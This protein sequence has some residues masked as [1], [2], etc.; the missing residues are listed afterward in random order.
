MRK[1]NGN[2]W[3]SPSL[4]APWR[5]TDEPQ[6]FPTHLQISILAHLSKVNTW[7]QCLKRRPK[8][9]RDYRINLSASPS[10]DLNYYLHVFLWRFWSALTL[11]V[12]PELDL[13]EAYACLLVTCL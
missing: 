11:A 2:L 12:L 4:V 3:L 8:W 10:S 1:R 13:I 6:S 9:G 5:A 7:E